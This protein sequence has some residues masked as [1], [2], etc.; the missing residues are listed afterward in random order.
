MFCDFLIFVVLFL[1]VQNFGNILPLE[2]T[3]VIIYYIRA[4]CQ[5]D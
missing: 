3:V 1:R 2:L 5:F 4:K